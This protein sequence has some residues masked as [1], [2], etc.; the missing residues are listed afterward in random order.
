MKNDPDAVRDAFA[1]NSFLE[2]DD[3]PGDEVSPLVVGYAWVARITA[4]SAEF[5]VLV[6]FGW[7]LDRSYGW[8]PLGILSGVVVGVIAFVAGLIAT[9]RRLEDEEVRERLRQLGSKKKR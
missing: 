6:W 9:A 2:T 7:F 5:A 8:S 3:D 1:L 4:Y